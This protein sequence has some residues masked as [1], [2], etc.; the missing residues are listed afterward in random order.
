MAYKKFFVDRD[1]LDRR[2]IFSGL[3]VQDAVDQQQRVPMRKILLNLV[4]I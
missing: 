3:P 2:D 1:I 4:D